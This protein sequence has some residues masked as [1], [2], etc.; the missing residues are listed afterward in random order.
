[1]FGVTLRTS[2]R[3]RWQEPAE[4]LVNH[5]AL[6]TPEVLAFPHVEKS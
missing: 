1:M 3:R 4:K 6:Q 5:F 2:G